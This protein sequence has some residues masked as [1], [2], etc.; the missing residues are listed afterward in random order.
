MMSTIKSE[1]CELN[2]SE[3]EMVSGSIKW[4]E[5]AAMIAGLS[6]FSPV[7]MAFGFPI[8]GAMLIIDHY[9]G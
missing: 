1:L 4:A 7:T 9:A 3:I 8:A 5:G 2:M 6:M